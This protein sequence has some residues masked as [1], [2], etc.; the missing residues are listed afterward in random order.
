MLALTAVKKKVENM[1][2]MLFFNTIADMQANQ[3]RWSPLSHE[4]RAS[5]CGQNRASER[6]CALHP[7]GSPM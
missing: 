2:K 3:H 5:I 7:L 4:I 6:P 1:G